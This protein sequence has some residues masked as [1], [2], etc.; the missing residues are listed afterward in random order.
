MAASV[1]VPVKVVI[2]IEPRKLIQ[3][4]LMTEARPIVESWRNSKVQDTG[5][6]APSSNKTPVL[7]MTI[8]VSNQSIKSKV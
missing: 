7:V 2:G 4:D 3:G 1:D 8:I 5:R 6:L